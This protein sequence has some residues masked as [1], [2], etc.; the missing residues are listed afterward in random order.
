[1]SYKIGF[2]A[3][4][5][6][7]EIL[8]TK[9][10]QQNKCTPRKSLVD[11]YF[12]E[13]GCSFTYFNDNFD[14]KKGDIVF[15]DGK[16]E[17]I[18]GL[19]TKVSYNFKIKLSDY[20]K[21]IAVA[22]TTISGKFFFANSHMISFNKS[23]IPYSKVITWY[24]AKGNDEEEIIYGED[25]NTE[26]YKL[27]DFPGIGFTSEIVSRGHEYYTDNNVV[28]ISVDGTK[29]KA[30]VFG[31]KAYEVDFTYKNGM[32]SSLV[33]DCYCNYHC[34]HEAA[35]MFQLSETINMI[36]KNYEDK[37]SESEYFAAISKYSLFSVTTGADKPGSIIFD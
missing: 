36:E 18:R 11:V 3:N 28:Y 2:T 17:G 20:K 1:M 37:L 30:I 22:D 4:D 9:I 16:F 24:K 13:N 35:V 29:G 25:D 15:V 8:D 12:S 32:I 6:E 10:T 26:E 33:C 31:S 23:T 34:K 27:D 14:L 19:V 5:Y 7:K 21:V